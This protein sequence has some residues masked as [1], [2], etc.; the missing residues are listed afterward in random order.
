[1]EPN[2]DSIECPFC[3]HV[4]GSGELAVTGHLSK[5]LEE[6]SLLALPIGVNSNETSENGSELGDSDDDGENSHEISHPNTKDKGKSTAVADY[7]PTNGEQNTPCNILYVN[8]P[9]EASEEELKAILSKQQG[10][11]RALFRTTQTY[12]LRFVEF[13]D[14]SSALKAILDL[15]G[16]P[17]PLLR[18]VERGILLSFAND[19]RGQ[20]GE[21]GIG[22]SR[23]DSWPKP[24]PTEIPPLPPGWA[25]FCQEKTHRVYYYNSNTNVTHWEEPLFNPLYNPPPNMSPIH[26][27]WIPLFDHGYQRWYYVN[28]ETG[29]IQWEAPCINP[30]YNP[31]PVPQGWIALFDRGHQRWYYVNQETGRTQW[32]T[33][34]INSA[35]FREDAEQEAQKE[36]EQAALE[37]DERAAVISKKKEE[38]MAGLVV[39]KEQGDEHLREDNDTSQ[40]L[41]TLNTQN[42]ATPIRDPSRTVMDALV[43]PFLPGS[44]WKFISYEGKAGTE[45]IDS[46][47]TALQ[48]S[49]AETGREQAAQE[50][51]RVVRKGIRVAKEEEQTAPEEEETAQEAKASATRE[52]E[53]QAAALAPREIS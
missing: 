5:H 22:G 37:A 26:Q 40:N 44:D 8:L 13:D 50:E 6:I 27:G 14:T 31:P 20:L 21:L 48:A 12:P 2:W 47:T 1:M 46:Q 39:K 42:M 25:T 35:A 43:N 28:Q 34:G 9:I 45:T 53:N 3:K 23:P 16:K 33:P 7:G 18:N 17:Q 32:D 36:K 51:V 10:F 24:L 41:Q 30:P 49:A 4:T 52:A 15:H 29:R 19:F 11:K 38:E